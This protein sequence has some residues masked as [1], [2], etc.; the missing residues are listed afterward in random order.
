MNDAQRKIE[1]ERFE[2]WARDN[3]IGTGT[4]FQASWLAWQAALAQSTPP[5]DAERYKFLR[6][7]VP[8]GSHRWPRWRVEYWNGQFWSPLSGA[9]LDKQIDLDAAPDSAQRAALLVRCDAALAEIDAAQ[10]DAPEGE[11]HDFDRSKHDI[12]CARCGKKATHPNHDF[13][14]APDGER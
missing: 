1:R 5:R 10:A 11:R 13:A 6:G 3:L 2:E 12:S 4:M 9:T 14:A 8:Q 7:D